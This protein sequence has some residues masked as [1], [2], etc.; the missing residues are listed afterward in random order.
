M[1]APGERSGRWSL[2]DLRGR[3]V[4][5]VAST[6]G[7]LTQLTRL[8]PRL[9]VDPGSPWVTFDTPQSRSLLAGHEVQYVPYVHP[10]DWRGVIKATRMMAPL[11][12]DVDGALSTGA[13]LALAALPHSA[14]TK[15]TVYLESISRVEGPSLTGR[16]LAR[17]PYIGMYAQHTGWL[18]QPW[19]AGP[20][21]L[22]LYRTEPL[23]TPRTVR[24]I[25]VTLGTIRP[26]R[27]DRMIDAVL[28]FA[29]RHPDA[30]ILWQVGVTT[31]DDLPGRVVTQL[32]DAEFGEALA[33]P[34]LVFA[35][36]GV[37]VAMNILDRGH[38][39]VLLDRR[40]ELGE[41]VDGHQ[42]EILQYL[43]GRGLAVEASTLAADDGVLERVL[44]TRVQSG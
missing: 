13:G 10:R 21:V 23:A 25:F 9:G 8:A 5:L 43:V 6:G 29:S 33:S 24:R 15:P 22:G 37:G 32:G 40:P 12:A 36:S 1:R 42:R 34:D 20:S 17:L 16:T 35:H 3:R 14:R 30:E 18:R 41:H 4:L 2:E 31:R 38:I 19:R 39:P 26:Y 44:A 27:F 7:H 28:A 11:L